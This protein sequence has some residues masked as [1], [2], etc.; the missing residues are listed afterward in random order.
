MSQKKNGRAD[1][2]REHAERQLLVL[3]ER[4]RDEVTDDDDERPTED[5]GGDQDAMR[6]SGDDAG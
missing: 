4:A 3:D 5:A 6:R 2:R 1:E